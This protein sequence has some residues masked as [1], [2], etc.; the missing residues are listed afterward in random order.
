MKTEQPPVIRLSDYG[1][2]DYAVEKVD[3]TFDLSPRETIVTSVLEIRRAEG[4]TGPLTL[5]GEDL[6][7]RHIVL[8]SRPLTADDMTVTESGLT[9]LDPPAAFTLATKVA[10]A[11]LDNT[12]LEGL[13]QSNGIYCT[14]CE[15]EGFRRITYFPDRPDVMSVY[16]V[17]VRASKDDCPILLSNGNNVSKRDLEDGRHE[18]VWHDP[19]PKP[20][21]LFALVAGNLQ[22]FNDRFTTRSGRA[23]SLHIWVEPGNVP[24]AAYAMDA[25]KR[26]MKWDEDRFDLEYD[27]DVFNIVAVSDF[28]MGAMENKSLN[29]FNAKYILADP[30]TATDADYANIEAIVGHEYF[31]N[32]TGNRVTCRDWFQLSLKEGLTVFRDQEFSADMRSRAVKRIQDVR[33][34][35]ARQFPEDAGPLAHPV[36]PD[37]YMEINNFYTATVYE[38]GA[39]V[40][41]MLHALLGEPGFQ[42]GMKLYFERHDG[43][44]VTCDDFV[45]AM[46]DATDTDLSAFKVWYSQAGTPEVTAKWATDAAA[47]VTTLVL[48]QRTEPTPGQTEKSP[49]PIPIA[50]GL[51]GGDGATIPLRVDGKDLGPETVLMLNEERLEVAFETGAARDVTPSLN[52][53]FSAPVIM[54]ADYGPEARACLMAHDTDP[55]ARWEAGQQYATALLL[56]MVGDLREGRALKPDGGFVAALGAMLGEDELD[57]AFRALAAAL[58]S[59]DYLAEQMRPVAVDEIH[60]AR[61]RLRRAIGAELRETFQWL[62]DGMSSEGPY[63]PG[64]E[65]AGRRSLRNAALAYLC[66]EDTTA[67]AALAMARFR[68]A[69]NMTDRM[70]ALSV[71]SDMTDPCREEAL[72]AFHARFKDDEQ[73]MDKW[74]SVQATS[75]RP[76]TLGRVRSLMDH[77]VFSLRKPNKV[78]ALIGAFAMAN[79]VRFHAADGSGYAFVA[80]TLIDLDKLNPQV[81]AR[82]LGAFGQWRRLPADRSRLMRGALERI[83][84]TEGLSRDCT[85]IDSFGPSPASW[86]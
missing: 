7:L 16:K 72:D 85:E 63:D 4:A 53:G 48:A 19:F 56:A 78:R 59:E 42:A 64:A 8:D 2:P 43:Q 25:L 13:Y 76:D 50:L 70:A 21:Y 37:S 23:V 6:D 66:A 5:D 15:A 62:H 51:L 71:L 75:A 49:V 38:K 36:R 65:A 79:P 30:E 40:I 24:R 31:H 33:M 45:A 17:T 9:L 86:A 81:A 73:V 55:F 39:E 3:L 22:A 35:R 46:A 10:I 28:N 74:L 84:G 67:A 27:L 82:L 12:R 60:E 44:A 1:P 58:P 34:L 68:E 14:Q 18:A 26:S 47:G 83:A 80:D 20:S 29:V 32:W 57:P 61:T 11:P 54:K 77:P 69:D 41:R 52:R